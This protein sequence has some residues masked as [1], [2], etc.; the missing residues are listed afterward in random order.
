MLFCSYALFVLRD[1]LLIEWLSNWA[2]WCALLWSVSTSCQVH[3][4][5]HFTWIKKVLGVAWNLQSIKNLLP[6]ELSQYSKSGS[7]LSSSVQVAAHSDCSWL[8]NTLRVFARPSDPPKPEQC[9]RAAQR[10]WRL[11]LPSKPSITLWHTLWGDCQTT[12]RGSNLD[13]NLSSAAWLTS[14]KG[15]SPPKPQH[16]LCGIPILF[17]SVTDANLRLILSYV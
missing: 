17:K 3:Q 12:C 4:N 8:W 11:I 1:K 2:K 5:F 9:Q 13:S 15:L 10:A 14:C 7:M 16:K 6:L